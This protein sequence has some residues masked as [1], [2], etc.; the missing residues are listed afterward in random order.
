ML[1]SVIPAWGIAGVTMVVFLLLAALVSTMTIYRPDKSDLKVRKVQF[2]LMGIFSVLT[3]VALNYVLYLMNIRIS[4]QYND[5]MLHMLI[6]AGVS[7]VVFVLIG[8][9]LS[10]IFKSSKIGT[11]F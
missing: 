10:K 9:V 3:G 7:F 2:W 11:W 6:A 8:F 4:N 1:F 5:Y